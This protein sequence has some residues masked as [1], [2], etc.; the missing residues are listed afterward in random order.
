MC[1]RIDAIRPFEEASWV[2][3]VVVVVE[4]RRED[5]GRREVNPRWR[6]CRGVI[7]Y[8]YLFSYVYVQ[9]CTYLSSN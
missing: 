6:G 9:R 7:I 3:L 4:R 2:A 5:R 8:L 1:G